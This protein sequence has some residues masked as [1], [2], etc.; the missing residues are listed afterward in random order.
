MTCRVA[1]IDYGMG[2]LFSVRQA[3]E[4][5]G[6]DV[7]FVDSPRQISNADVLV[8]PGVGAF[9]DGMRGL[10]ER[11]LIGAIQDHAGTGRP[12]LGIC[13]G[14]QM[15]LDESEEFGISKGLGLISGRVVAIP[16]TD[17]NGQAHRIP[18]IGWNELIHPHNSPD[19][20][21]DSILRG[22]PP[23]ESMYFVHSFN[24]LP[25][26]PKN[27]LAD[28]YYG[29]VRISAAIRA[30]MVYGCQFHPEKSGPRG[31][32]IIR[33]FLSTCEMR[34]EFRYSSHHHGNH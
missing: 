2:N 28:C 24:A 13:L 12:M 9:K 3:L 30:G 8:L 1:L 25:A 32:Q 27:R 20:W 11:D 4:A 19:E 22:I 33:N 10:E 21:E 29:G 23:G 17:I 6:A 34:E 16:P 31:L 7:E 18:H 14:M 5:C 26:N 15:L